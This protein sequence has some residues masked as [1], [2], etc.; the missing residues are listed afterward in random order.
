MPNS[1]DVMRIALLGGSFNPLH[2]GHLTI[3][4]YVLDN[5]NVDS[6]S[7]VLSPH[8]PWKKID[9]LEDAYKRLADL[10]YAVDKINEYRKT[11]SNGIFKPIEVCDVE[12]KLPKPI[13]TYNT[14]RYLFGKYPDNEY[15]WIIGADNAAAIE[16]WY[17]W[18]DIIKE[19]EIWVYPRSG[20]D[21]RALC[22][23]YRLRFLD[24]PMVDISSTRIR[25]SIK[26]GDNMNRYKNIDRFCTVFD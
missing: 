24:A 22:E 21:T 23:K 15:I 19:I 3:A 9:D 14:L 10:R 26:A 17:R 12:F 8:N 5:C 25:E 20:Y 7:F 11:K 16:R 18:K 13:Y 2:I 6:L 4:R 1:T